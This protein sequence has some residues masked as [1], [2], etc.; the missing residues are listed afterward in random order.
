MAGSLVA[1]KIEFCNPFFIYLCNIFFANT[2]DYPQ[3]DILVVVTLFRT[4]L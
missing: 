3:D 4:F 2:T 1:E